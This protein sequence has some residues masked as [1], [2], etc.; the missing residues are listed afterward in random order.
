MEPNSMDEKTEW[1]ASFVCGFFLGPL[2][3]NI[4]PFING[5]FYWI[6]AFSVALTVFYC[7]LVLCGCSLVDRKE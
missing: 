4:S 3:L 7:I 5:C 2:L 1:I 6:G